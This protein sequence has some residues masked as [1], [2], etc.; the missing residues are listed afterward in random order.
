[1]EAFEKQKDGRTLSFIEECLID[2]AMVDHI[3]FKAY[4]DLLCNRG[5]TTGNGGTGIG[6]HVAKSII[7]DGHQGALRLYNHPSLGAGVQILLP[8]VNGHTTKD[9]RREITRQSLRHQIQN[10]LKVVA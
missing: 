5:A 2:E 4:A 8:N 6:L 7:E 10:G 9:R 1:M 3:S